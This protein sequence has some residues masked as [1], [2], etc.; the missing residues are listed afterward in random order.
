M[1]YYGLNLHINIFSTIYVLFPLLIT[2]LH[3]YIFF[4]VHNIMAN[5]SKHPDCK[6]VVSLSYIVQK[7][8]L[9]DCFE[10]YIMHIVYISVFPLSKRPNLGQTLVMK[11]SVSLSKPKEWLGALIHW[12]CALCPIITWHPLK[13]LP[14]S[15]VKS[16]THCSVS[17]AWPQIISNI[18]NFGLVQSCP[19]Q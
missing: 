19:T 8:S 1:V 18:N 16:V 5:F 3:Q 4:S 17:L 12:C 6:E 10:C 14:K 11:L 2:L 7:D 15:D 13:V 9:E